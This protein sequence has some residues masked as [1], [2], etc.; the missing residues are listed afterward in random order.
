MGSSEMLHITMVRIEKNMFSS[1]KK[2]VKETESKFQ[3][4]YGLNQS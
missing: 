1:R 3:I 4:T 2:H